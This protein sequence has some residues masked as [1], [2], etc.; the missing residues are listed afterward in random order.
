M[1]PLSA[2]ALR[3]RWAL[4]RLQRAAAAP[5]TP[6]AGG[7]PVHAMGL[8]FP[9]PLGL[10]AGFDRRGG[11]LEGAHRLGFGAV[12]IGTLT[13]AGGQ[14]VPPLRHVARQQAR[15]GVSIGKPPWIDWPLAEE[16]F[17]R[18]F[19]AFHG[20]ADYLTLNPGRGYPSAARFAAVAAVVAR[21]RDRFVRRR[22]LPIVVKLPP[23]WLAG[24]ERVRTAASFLANG[25]D[26]LL[27][28][29]EG[30]AAPGEVHTCLAELSAAFGSRACLI[31]V[32]GIDSATEAAARLRAGAQLVQLHRALIT[33]ALQPLSS[34]LRAAGTGLRV[35]A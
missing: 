33:H 20:G 7:T 24:E 30:V 12:E 1:M 14:G 19:H 25:A 17:L 10:A 13:A 32:G 11:L 27:L 5:G 15:C 3:T 26:G 18:A 22:P 34:L 21:A 2:S 23:S 6:R 35:R 28:S 9:G 16:A 8:V 29:A 4:Q 31:S